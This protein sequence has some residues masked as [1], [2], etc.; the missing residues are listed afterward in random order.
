MANITES[1][2]KADIVA[3]ETLHS[4]LHEN[5]CEQDPLTVAMKS[6]MDPDTLYLWEARKEP[7]FPK[8]LE[9]MQKEVDD[10]TREGHWRLVRR[11]D[12]PKG[13]TVLPAVWSMKRKRRIA[14]REVYKWKARINIDGSKQVYG[15]HYN[16]TY[17]PVVAWPM[18]RFFLT[19]SLLNNWT[20]KQID[21]VLAFPQAPVERDLYMEIPKGIHVEGAKDG[22]EYVLQLVRNLN[23]QK[24]AGRVWYQYLVDGLE[25][26]GFTRSE[27]DECVFYYKNSVL[28]VYVDDSILMGPDN[29]EL[30]YL[31]Q[32]MQKRFKIQEEGDLCDY[33]GIEIKKESD[34]SMTLTQPQLIDS[35]LQDLKLNG[36]NVKSRNTPAL[37][38]RVL[39]KDE[40]GTVFDESFHYRSVIGKL[41]YLEKSTHPDIS[42][43]VHQC[44]RFS[45]NPK[46]S[47]AMAVHYIARYLAATREKGITLAPT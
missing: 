3:Y 1:D 32:E 37:K 42:F 17:S 47:H 14:T 2:C 5:V 45:S 24:Q 40:K 19:Q 26:I 11:K 27:V 44:A 34:G 13:A 10:H 9:A 41:N 6:V 36:D 29:N 7:D 22:E 35:I 18:T 21:F 23:G 12:V 28:L 31:L 46:Q 39:H 30:A 33:L 20:T 8:F 16:E 4:P 43:A 15:V 25:D 38:T